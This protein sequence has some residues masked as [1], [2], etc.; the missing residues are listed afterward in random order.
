MS[1]SDVEGNNSTR[2]GKR[3]RYTDDK[4]NGHVYLTPSACEQGEGRAVGQQDET[5][6]TKETLEDGAGGRRKI[7][8]RW[9][10]TSDCMIVD[11]ETSPMRHYTNE[12]GRP[13]DKQ[14]D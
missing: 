2:S 10:L 6:G 4:D 13:Q 14:N 5:D 7:L 8:G 9:R 11:Q 12:C 3:D 1:N